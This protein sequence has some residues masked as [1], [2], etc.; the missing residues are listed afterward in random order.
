MQHAACNY[1]A[2]LADGKGTL[3]ICWTGCI[4]TGARSAGLRTEPP[5]FHSGVH[6]ERG[7]PLPRGSGRDFLTAYAVTAQLRELYRFARLLSARLREIILQ[8][9]VPKVL[10][11][12]NYRQYPS[13][14]VASVRSDINLRYFRRCDNERAHA[15]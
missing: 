5:A 14:V 10:Y 9:C 6:F 8:T 7:P 1:P 2:F 4:D 3:Q 12:I 13:R 11:I 15:S